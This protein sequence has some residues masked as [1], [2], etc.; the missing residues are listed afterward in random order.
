MVDFNKCCE[1]I[2]GSFQIFCSRWCKREHVG[3]HVYNTW[4]LNLVLDI[5]DSRFSSY[6]N[7]LD[8]LPP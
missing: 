3:S 6:C 8:I 1:L 2:A 7:N 5:I 4:K